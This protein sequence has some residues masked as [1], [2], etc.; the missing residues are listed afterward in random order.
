MLTFGKA[1]ENGL[2]QHPEA[3]QARTTANYLYLA[4]VLALEYLSPDKWYRVDE[5]HRFLGRQVFL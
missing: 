2:G 3:L 4:T 1:L 5:F